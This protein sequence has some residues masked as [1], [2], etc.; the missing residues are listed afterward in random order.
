MARAPGDNARM[1][2]LI[3]H[4]LL[5][6]RDLVVTAGPFVALVLLLLGLAY[7]LLDPMPPRH[8]VLATGPAQ[9]AYAAWG[10]RYAAELKAQGITVELRT[11]DGSVDNLRLLLDDAAGVDLAFVRNG[12]GAATAPEGTLWSLS[13]LFQEPVWVFYRLPPQRRATAPSTLASLAGKRVNVGEPGSGVPQLMQNLWALNGLEPSQLRLSGEPDNI[14]I[15]QMLDGN[16]DAVVVVSAPEPPLVQMLLITPGIGLLNLEQAQAYAR[17]LP[18][19]QTVDLPRGI[20]DLARDVPPES[21]DMVAA[22]TMLVA[23]KDTHPALRQLFVQAADRLHRPAGWFQAQ[24]EFPSRR[25]SELPIDP[26]ATRYY[27]HGQPML[28]RYLPFGLANLVDRMWVVLVSLLAVLLPL[29]RIVPPL[30]VFRI[31]SRIFRW[32]GRLRDI[33]D[34]LAKGR[35]DPA[36]LAHELDTLD[37]Q[38]EGLNVPLAYAEELY[39]LRS[40]IVL[41]RRKVLAPAAPLP[42]LADTESRPTSGSAP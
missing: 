8:M 15:G 6:A 42:H 14:A 38:L 25:D 23:R 11:T 34:G 30:Y 39:A 20:V 4:T 5:S 12:A 31:R 19:V 9:S 36:A 17:R 37:H 29:S 1:T 35:G 28:Q 10:E 40:H 27:D 22:T 24:G 18:Q 41:V 33:E 21:V 26:E 2:R 13:G 32:Y 7:W 16:L 3:R